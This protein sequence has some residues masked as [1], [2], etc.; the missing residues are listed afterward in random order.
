MD[1][2]I[3]RNERDISSSRCGRRWRADCRK[4]WRWWWRRICDW[5]L[6]SFGGCGADRNSWSGRRRR[7]YVVAIGLGHQW[8]LHRKPYI[9]W[10]WSRQ[11]VLER[12]RIC[13]SSSEWWRSISGANC[14]RHRSSNSRWRRRW[15]LVGRRRC[16]WGY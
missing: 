15:R 4:L 9:W 2:A 7:A 5:L 14:Q 16:R 1:S 13:R 8:L 6:L 3:G 11:F 12:I 10:R